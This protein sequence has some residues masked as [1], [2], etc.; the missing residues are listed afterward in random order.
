MAKT[1]HEWIETDVQPIRR[2]PVAWLSP[3][4]FF[5]DPMR[6]TYSDLG[7]FFPPADGVILYQRTLR[8]EE[9]VMTIKG[10]DCSLKDALGAGKN[11]TAVRKGTP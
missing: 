7:Y 5:R 4:H 8:P 10:K 6:P 3:H 1:L 2:K 11:G 9:C